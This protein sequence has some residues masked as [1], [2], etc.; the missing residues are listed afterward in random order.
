MGMEKTEVKVKEILVDKLGVDLDSITKDSKLGDD[1]GVDSLDLIEII[2]EIES[3]Y[4]MYILDE[5]AE[6]W[7]TV[8]DVIKYAFEKQIQG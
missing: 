8:E 6:K 1:L 4:D 2:M 5:D 3:T 7:E